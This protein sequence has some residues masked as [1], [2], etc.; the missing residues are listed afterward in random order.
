M[1]ESLFYLDIPYKGYE[2]RFK[3]K[4]IV[5]GYTHKFYVDVE[6]VGVLFEPDEQRRYRAVL[7]NKALE[8]NRIPDEELTMLVNCRISELFS[9]R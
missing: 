3:A 4:L 8:K 1:E 6:G 2:R 9:R 5:S 7:D